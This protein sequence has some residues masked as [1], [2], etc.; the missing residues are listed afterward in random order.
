MSKTMKESSLKFR[1]S[2][3]FGH[4][5]LRL[6]FARQTLPQWDIAFCYVKLNQGNP[7][8]LS[9]NS[10]TDNNKGVLKTISSFS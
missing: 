5:S 8:D 2:K 1:S 4:Q 6:V 3:G 10:N 9:P 7:L